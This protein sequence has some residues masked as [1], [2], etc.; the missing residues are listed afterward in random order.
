MGV[1]MRSAC[2]ATAEDR[3]WC[4]SGYGIDDRVLAAQAKP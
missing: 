1:V 3:E 4:I 2:T